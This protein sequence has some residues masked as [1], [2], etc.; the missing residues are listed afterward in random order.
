MQLSELQQ[1]V[2]DAV[3]DG[4]VSHLAS[5]LV[6]GRDPLRR[7][8]I[9]QRH[10]EASL[11]AAVLGRFPA[12]AWLVGSTCLESAAR[13]FVHAHPPTTPC[14][15]EYGTA[16]PAF[17]AAWDGTAH[18]GYLSSFAALD[19]QLGRL[20]V[21]VDGPPATQAVLGQFTPEALMHARA[22]LQPGAYYV[23]ATWPI[24][25]LITSYLADRAPEAWDLRDE[26][27][28]LE[29]R[30][31]RGTFRFT[32]L[33]PGTFAFRDALAAGECLGDAAGRGLDSGVPFDPADAL[34]RLIHE[35]LLTGITPP[36]TGGPS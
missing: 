19:W 9:H 7:F 4:D 25:E 10:Y 15:A 28:H 35:G 3:V 11:T 1:R 12:T 13:I 30:G 34:L 18:L 17:L 32:R 16:F 2:R 31:T 20:A 24:D 23:H 5:A 21:C 8:A 6:G 36:D 26:A 22:T 14:I 33:D 27:V 29:V